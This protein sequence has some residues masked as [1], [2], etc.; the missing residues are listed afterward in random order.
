M[1]S[2]DYREPVNR[3]HG[4]LG[5]SSDHEGPTRRSR[6][7]AV[8][9]VFAVALAVAAPAQGT[10]SGRLDRA[11]RAPGVSRDWT[12]A[13]VFDLNRGSIVY[14]H[15]GSLSLRPA[16]NE[17]LTVAVT[18][19]DRL[20]PSFRIPT[21]VLGDGS[22][23]PKGVWRGRL[24]L[25]GYGN[26]ALHSSGLRWLAER[27]RAQGVVKVT[28]AIVG[29]ETYF[30]KARVGPGWKPSFYKEES[31]PLSALIVD[32]ARIDGHISSDPARAAAILFKRALK[33][34]GI[35]V[36]GRVVKD[37]A[38]PEAVLLARL[39]SRRSAWLIRRMNLV[40]DNFYAEMLLKELGARIEGTGSTRA[41]ARVVRSTL[42]RHLTTMHGV[43]IADGSGLSAYDRLT[44][45]ALTELLIWAV[46]DDAIRSP[47]VASL[48]IAGVRGT[49]K[50]RMTS[51]PAYR[52]VY[53]KTGTTDR[54]SALSGYATNGSLSPRYVFSVLMNGNPIPWW[55]AR[56]AQDRFGQVLAGAAQ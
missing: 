55:Y 54:A 1:A 39:R 53:A 9:V 31:P 44:A 25:K 41:G 3:N 32:R 38:P 52:H 28:G 6:I 21:E 36:P 14:R 18:V 27:I 7:P 5:P 8:A 50:D 29:D 10:L 30:D 4:P 37:R 23:T 48:P 26:P 24:V 47:L 16:S 33:A 17:K 15:H 34:A 43:R 19:L 11:L 40:S 22:F 49:L 2:P 13:F 35:A 42:R 45:R 56:E 12:G 46:S 20:G 51:A